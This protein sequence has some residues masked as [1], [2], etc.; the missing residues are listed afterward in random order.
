[1]TPKTTR[2]NVARAAGV[3]LALL[4]LVLLCPAPAA[5]QGDGP[6]SQTLLPTGYNFVVP[7]YL[8]LD[9]DYDFTGT[10]LQPNADVK[11]DI[12]VVT[13]T[14]AF[15]LGGRYAQIWI[16]PIFGSID[17][18]VR[19]VNRTVNVN[20]SGLGDAVASF[21]V[22]LVG[23]PARGIP[24]FVKEPQTFQVSAFVSTT[25]P[26]GSYDRD[27]LLNL[28]T[29]RWAVRVGTPIVMPWGTNTA[30]ATFLE[31]FPSVSFFQDNDEPTG[32]ATLKSQDPLFQLESHL[33]HNF[34]PKFW[35]SGDLRYFGGGE[36]TTDG[37]SDDNH[38][39]ETGAG[40]SAGYAIAKF[41]SVQASYARRLKTGDQRDL[42]MVRVKL[43]LVF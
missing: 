8:G 11:S 33:S 14:R 9:G 19:A 7:A 15:S 28:G 24:A 5:A 12:F 27:R 38:I 4:A 37:I 16:N 18:D 29:N 34:H 40:V 35:M 39:N 21:K 3:G 22:G 42:H 13:Y 25:I 6:R 23:A 30:R 32:G 2:T 1:M 43:A 26:V 10:I 36:T 31:V 20:T 17:A 41:L